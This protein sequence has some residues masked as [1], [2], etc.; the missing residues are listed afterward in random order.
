MIIGVG[1]SVPPV[2]AF[3]IHGVSIAVIYTQPLIA[4]CFISTASC[5]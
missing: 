1:D 4:L 3:S 2:V 5:V